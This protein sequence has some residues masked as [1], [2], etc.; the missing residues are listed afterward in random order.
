MTKLLERQRQL[1]AEIGRPLLDQAFDTLK[2]EI[3]AGPYPLDAKWFALLERLDAGDPMVLLPY[4]NVPDEIRAH[5]E[6]VFRDRKLSRQGQ[7]RPPIPTFR[8]VSLK[9]AKA[10]QA[11]RLVSELVELGANEEKSIE[12]VSLLYKGVPTRSKIRALPKG[13]SSAAR[14]LQARRAAR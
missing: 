13:E 5:I 12:L 3:D 2:A 10:T 4:L 7:K 9:E 11:A 8:P 14:N 1:I 6:D